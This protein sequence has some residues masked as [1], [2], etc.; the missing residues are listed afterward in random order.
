M[1]SLPAA[2]LAASRALSIVRQMVIDLM[3][4]HGLLY[5]AQ[6]VFGFREREAEIFSSQR[7][8]FL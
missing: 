2:R 8:T 7:A 6:Q 3:G 5:T 4:D 1:L